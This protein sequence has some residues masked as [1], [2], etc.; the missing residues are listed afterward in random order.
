[1]YS[2]EKTASSING[3]RKTGELHGKKIKLNY[4]LTPYTE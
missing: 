3:A 4:F 1:M 2:W